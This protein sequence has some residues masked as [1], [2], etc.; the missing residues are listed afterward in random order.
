TP[1]NNAL[2]GYAGLVHDGGSQNRGQPQQPRL[3]TPVVDCEPAGQL[4]VQL[5]L[6]RILRPHQ[7][8]LQTVSGIQDPV[9]VV[10]VLIFTVFC[11]NTEE[12]LPRTAC[13]GPGDVI[14]PVWQLY[15][16]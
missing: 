6:V 8:E 4:A 9:T 13:A 3:V 1:F 11:R 10:D 12:R 14:V 16:H 2:N 7:P 5:I 15:P